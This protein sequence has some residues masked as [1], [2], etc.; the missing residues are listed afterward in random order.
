MIEF[1]QLKWQTYLPIFIIAI[2]AWVLLRL[3]ARLE[4]SLPMD[5]QHAKTIVRL[6]RVLLMIFS[7]LLC[8]QATGYPISGL[9]A[10]GGLGTVVVGLAAKDA[11]ANFFGA[12]MIYFDRPFVEGDWIRS[13][14]RAIEGYVE[15]VGWRLTKIRTFE[16]HPLY[17]PNA[18]FTS[19]LVENPSR[20]LNRRIKE[21][22]GIR[23]ADADKLPAML[24]DIQKMLNKNSDLDHKQPCI[25]N[26]VRFGSFSLECLVH[27]F[28]RSTGLSEYL[29]A[30]Q[31]LFFKIIEI[32]HQHGGELA[33]SVSPIHTLRS[34]S[35]TP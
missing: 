3:I 23:Y 26:F 29:L 31:K 28:T 1:D 19:I 32:I 14:D 15:S 4:K 13:P 11:L 6:L 8:I 7:V 18:V 25:V 21:T 33:F 10:I 2:I 20:M 5:Q 16:R 17:V 22:F 24:E 9:L 30:Q 34:D 27:V 35:L 12:L